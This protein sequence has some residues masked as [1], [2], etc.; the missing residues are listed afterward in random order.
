MLLTVLI[1]L[2]KAQDVD[3]HVQGN[4]FRFFLRPYF[5]RYTILPRTSFESTDIDQSYM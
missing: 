3:L 1:K 5:L 2:A 4:E